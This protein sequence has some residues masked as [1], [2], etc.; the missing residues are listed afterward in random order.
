LLPPVDVS[1]FTLDTPEYKDLYYNKPELP[2]YPEGYQEASPNYPLERPPRAAS[3]FNLA[4]VPEFYFWPQFA[5]PEYYVND[6]YWP[7]PKD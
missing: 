5:K 4:K 3:N 7:Q 2:K 6:K 1:G